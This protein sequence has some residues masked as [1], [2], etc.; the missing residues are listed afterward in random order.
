V[1][2]ALD[3][4]HAAI[5]SAASEVPAERREAIAAFLAAMSAAAHDTVSAPLRERHAR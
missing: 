1:P 2:K 5:E 4:F 3:D